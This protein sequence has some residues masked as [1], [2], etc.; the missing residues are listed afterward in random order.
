VI[1]INKYLPVSC[2]WLAVI[3]LCAHQIIPHD[4]HNASPYAD[5]DKNCPA[6]ENKND[7]HTG[8]PVHCHAFNDLVSEKSR[9][10]HVSPNLNFNI[11]AII[12][13]SDPGTFQTQIRVEK[14]I[15]LLESVIDSAIIELHPLRAPPP[16]A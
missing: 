15:A 4:H 2:L 14:K 3:L 9:S 13:N 6:T 7:H 1:K 10:L 8:F 5:L 12:C 11:I 16:L